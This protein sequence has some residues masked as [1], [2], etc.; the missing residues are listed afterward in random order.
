MNRCTKVE[1]IKR[2]GLIV[3][4]NCGH[5]VIPNRSTTSGPHVKGR[6]VPAHL[7]RA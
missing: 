5:E 4:A 7:R 6:H 2:D 1:P 3:C